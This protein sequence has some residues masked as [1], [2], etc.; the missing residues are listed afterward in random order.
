[1]A[2]H[3]SID[4]L[5]VLDP[6][7]RALL[8]PGARPEWRPPM[9]ATLT[10]RYFSD[11]GWIFE[12]K[13]DG[14]RAIVVCDGGARLWSRN[15]KPLD[16]SFP[17]LV[18]ALTRR[19]PDGMV[20]DGEVVAFAGKQTS[21]S[22]LQP[23]LGVIDARRALA[24]G[25]R[26]F[27]YL[28]DLMTLGGYDLAGL[29]L[30][31]RKRVLRAAV[32][33]A[34]PVRYSTHRTTHGERYLRQACAQGWE[35]LIAKDAGSRYSTGRSEAWLKFKCVRDQE[36]VIGGYTDP[37]GSRIGFGAL[38]VGHYDDGRL[39]Y[40]GK[41]GTGYDDRTLRSLRARLDDLEQ[42]ASPFAD[43]VREPGSHWVRPE[44]VAQVGF[45]EWTSTGRLRHPRF[46]GLRVDKP[47]SEV[48]RERP[49][50]AR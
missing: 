5:D 47:A 16:T 20:A 26:V 12:R 7:E 32:D 39:R 34:S 22:L 25:T 18:D 48:V 14:V 23:R 41:V 45:T 21:F 8:R 49:E 11:Q 37:A 9:L 50:P 30:M 17:E 27:I 31:A 3:E 4:P 29:P 33:F 28:F 2:A 24:T 40:A 36:F 38:L 15:R 1:M 6:A 35:G 43:P 44:L 42:P 46:Q 13:L 10:D 19:A